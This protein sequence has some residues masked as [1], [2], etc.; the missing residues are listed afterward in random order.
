MKTVLKWIWRVFLGLV[1][2]LVGIF[3]AAA[4]IPQL[5]DPAIDME[6]HGAGSSSVLPSFSGLERSFPASNEPADNPTTPEKVELGR[7]LFFD[8]VLSQNNDIACASCH[9]PDLGFA[10][11][12]PTAAGPDG[13]PLGRNTPTLWN[14]AFAKNLFWDGRLDSLEA[15]SEFPLTHPDEMGVGDTRNLERELRAFPAYVS[16]FDGAFGGGEAALTLDNLE[17]ALA[18]YE[19]SLITRNSPFDRYAAGEFDALTPSQRR[20]LTLFRSG[21]TRCFECH[22]APTFASD[23]FRVVGVP[24]DDPG[25]AGVTAD[26]VPGAFKV[27]TLRN[28][29]LTA[30]YM[31]NGSLESLADVVQFYADGG[32]HAHDLPGIDP[33]VNGFDLTEQEKEDLVAFLF[34]LTDESSLPPP[35]AAVPSGLPVVSPRPNPA[36]ERAALVNVGDDRPDQD[37][38]EPRTLTVPAGGAIQPVVDRALAG[39]TV[40]IPYGVYHERVVIDRSDITIEGIPN[41]DG[42]FPIFDGQ[43][44]LPEG[45]LSSGNNFKVGRLHFRHFTDNGVLVEGATGVHFYDIVAENTGVYGV[46]PVRSTD[47]L[48]ERIE[49]FQVADAGIYAGQCVNVVV[50]DSVAYDNVIGIELE[51]TLNGEIYNNHTY[52]NTT[53]IF[54]VILPQL[55]S[56]I[57]AE[58][59]VYN[60]ISTANNLDNFGR[61]GSVVSLLPPGVGIL[62]LGSDRNEVYENTIEGNKTSGVAVFSLTGTGVFDVN[63]LDV[64]PLPEGNWIHDNRY[65]NNG[66]DPDQFVRDL[67][68]PVGDVLWDG[69][70]GGN[71]FDEPAGT[72]SFPPLLPSQDWPAFVRRAYG[73][74]LTVLIALVS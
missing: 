13:Q 17:K 74:I 33:F 6:N 53:G 21:A 7:L 19:R 68:I 42:E 59:K 22:T 67:G 16:L 65:Q 30:P 47:V 20:G 40:L 73:N 26:G 46:Y 29:A 48:I 25:R 27:P 64:G 39:D 37:A 69:S 60:N 70:G 34:A 14:V 49:V 45:I 56:K 41:E 9:H 44:V 57:S 71:R 62:I 43:G 3:T 63:E 51:N 5:A 8:P 28:I 18:A 2:L 10:D 15:Q 61:S 11:G 31:H 66:F 12:R 4:A 24:S 54:V 1:I 52:N 36:R 72:T 55:S 50:R 32:G 23:T 35:P 58:T 38:R